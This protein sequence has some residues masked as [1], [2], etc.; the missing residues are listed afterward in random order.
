MPAINN[1]LIG[2]AAKPLAGVGSLLRLRHSIKCWRCQQNGHSHQIHGHLPAE[3]LRRAREKWS[4]FYL[5][6]S[7]TPWKE[8]PVCAWDP[9]CCGPRGKRREIKWPPCAWAV[10]HLKEQKYFKWSWR[11]CLDRLQMSLFCC[12]LPQLPSGTGRSELA[13]LST[14]RKVA[15][16][17]AEGNLMTQITDVRTEG[18]RLLYPLRTGRFYLFPPKKCMWC[19]HLHSHCHRHTF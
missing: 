5:P 8:D 4:S 17:T 9:G 14:P 19:S 2:W 6:H 1:Q 18:Q 13:G 15:A 11:S 12:K 3:L 10:N 7:T 16:A